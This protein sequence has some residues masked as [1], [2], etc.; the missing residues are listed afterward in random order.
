MN[1]IFKNIQL[2]LKFLKIVCFYALL[3]YEL[4][5]Y[6][7]YRTNH[8]SNMPQDKML[9]TP[10]GWRSHKEQQLTVNKYFPHFCSFDVNKAL[11]LVG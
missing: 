11:F 5:T 1:K 7:D 4:Q 3:F 9:A 8:N 10:L 6:T 2:G